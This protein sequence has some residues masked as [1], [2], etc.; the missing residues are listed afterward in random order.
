[1][2]IRLVP[3]SKNGRIRFSCLNKKQ[4][5]YLQRENRVKAIMEID[6]K[7]IE[8]DK[9]DD[10]TSKKMKCYLSGTFVGDFTFK[11]LQEDD[12]LLYPYYDDHDK[13]VVCN[14]SVEEDYLTL[15]NEND[16]KTVERNAFA[17]ASHIEKGHEL[18]ITASEEATKAFD[19]ARVLTDSLYV[20][21]PFYHENPMYLNIMVKE[22]G[23]T[24]TYT[25][26]ELLE[27]QSSQVQESVLRQVKAFVPNL[28]QDYAKADDMK[29][30]F[31]HVL[32]SI[33]SEEH[34][35]MLSQEE[36]IQ[37]FLE[38]SKVI[39]E[40]K[41]ELVT[42]EFM[43]EIEDSNSYKWTT[44]RLL[45]K[46]FK[47]SKT[48]Q[49][50]VIQSVGVL[51]NTCANDR[52]VVY[53]LSDMGSGKT[54]MTV[55]AIAVLD[56]QLVHG[57]TKQNVSAL[58]KEVCVP[59]KHIITP[60]LSV[61][62]SWVET[63][64]LFYNVEKINDVY[65]K[66]SYEQDGIRVVS[67]LRFAPF[68]VKNNKTFTSKEHIL[69]DCPRNSYLIIDEIHQLVTKKIDRKKF[70]TN[71]TIRICEHY[72]SFILSGTLSNL[73]TNEWYNFLVFMGV[74]MEEYLNKKEASSIFAPSSQ[75]ITEAIDEIQVKHRKVLDEDE[76]TME[77]IFYPEEA[78]K[79]TKVEERFHEFYDSHF[80]R[81]VGAFA[82]SD[83]A[84]IK[85]ILM[86]QKS[87]FINPNLEETINFKLFYD[88]V[89]HA[90]IT[91]RSTQIAEELFQDQNL[92][93][94]TAIINTSSPLSREDIRTLKVL[95]NI[96]ENHKA[97]KSITI[98]K[99]I[100]NAILNLNDGLQ[101]QNIY[102][103]LGK[104]AKNNTRFFEYLTSLEIDVLEKVKQSS[105]IEMPKLEDSEKFKVLKDL[106][107]KEKEETHLIVVNDKKAMK[108]L[109]MALELEYF[110]DD[111]L[112]DAFG[113]Q[114]HI[115]ELY[116]KQSVVI[117][118]QSMIKSSLDIVQANRLIQYQLNT[119]ISDIIQSQNRIHRVG[120]TRNT[121]AYYIA[122]DALQKN[123]IDLFLESYKNI[124][125][126]H[127]GIVELFVDVTTQ[128]NIINN[129]L[130]QAFESLEDEER[131]EEEEVMDQILEEIAEK[132][133]TFA[134]LQHENNIAK[135]ILKPTENNC[136][137]VFVPTIEGTAFH[138][139]SLPYETTSF[140]SNKAHMVMFNLK[141]KVVVKTI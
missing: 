133:E 120:Q 36:Q 117:V 139:T 34:F 66:L 43:K 35:T 138:F 80:I 37:H 90:A 123:L 52:R 64:K 79:L 101:E 68:T 96:A 73:T 115:D 104:L 44:N 132:E 108:K 39:K 33:Q 11:D 141:E 7:S 70:F 5:L 97:Y 55:Q 6:H 137:E 17:F 54:L 113:Y 48:Q 103:L 21:N 88:V 23:E 69:P 18:F 58:Q 46:N 128:V 28:K 83:E 82:Q 30:I 124:K 56:H 136:F 95:H 26:L 42:D 62:S 24:K 109:A 65:Y 111:Q 100:H 1:M 131:Q 15:V 122:C 51:S 10:D 94:D 9:A 49:D 116:K 98:G 99:E 41:K 61:T 12:V 105:F 107:E 135:A 89:G 127:K 140:D 47:L 19:Y 106:L 87:I 16:Q 125:V 112:K 3:Y 118:P 134:H 13:A 110:S 121:K 93:H 32:S 77:D 4:F 86:R 25:I 45:E 53:N 60:T 129:Y 2:K 81:P 91:A 40:G 14:V 20:R 114:E 76:L 57:Y 75:E 71:S 59:E 85:N 126:A 22:H 8:F 119:E 102:D 67:D 84:T 92:T 78:G 130:N 63:F 29:S 72:R 74:N 50:N 31:K 27:R 38:F